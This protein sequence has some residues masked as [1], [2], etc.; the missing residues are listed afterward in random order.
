MTRSNKGKLT[1]TRFEDENFETQRTKTAKLAR[2]TNNEDRPKSIQEAMSHPTRGKQ[3]EKAIIHEYIK[4]HT[5][6][7]V[8]RPKDT[9]IVS[10]KCDFRHKKNEV[11]DIVRLTRCQRIQS[12]LWNRLPG[13]LCSC[14]QTC[15]SQNS[16][17]TCSNI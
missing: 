16:F 12:D 15:I 5:W 6:N 14:C 13:S 4:N 11:G 8:K 17:R 7:L 1:S 2:S 9:R 10:C 3:W